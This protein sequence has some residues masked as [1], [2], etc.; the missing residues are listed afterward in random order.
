MKNYNGH[1]ISLGDDFK[2]RKNGN[3]SF[4]KH[5]LL[6]AYSI[7]SSIGINSNQ[8]RL[9]WSKQFESACRDISQK[10]YKISYFRIVS[11]RFKVNLSFNRIP[12]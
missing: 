10:L 3:S 8:C 6:I 11:V 1:N 9:K 7:P 12:H 2:M 5:I 4:S